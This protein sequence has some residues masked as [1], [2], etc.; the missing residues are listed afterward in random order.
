MKRLIIIFLA[1]IIPILIW[2]VEKMLATRQGQDYKGPSLRVLLGLVLS[3][4]III[5][6]LLLSQSSH[7]PEG[8]KYIPASSQ[9]GEILPGIFNKN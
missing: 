3:I 2:Y 5:V 6:S 8:S 1:L 9:N 7:A 4:M